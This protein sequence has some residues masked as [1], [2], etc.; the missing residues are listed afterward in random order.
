[1]RLIDAESVVHG[2]WE[3]QHLECG[4]F[5]VCSECE[6]GF[7]TITEYCPK[8]GAKMDGNDTNVGSKE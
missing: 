4:I 1:M 5:Y 2:K 8:C 7:K 6:H 3:L